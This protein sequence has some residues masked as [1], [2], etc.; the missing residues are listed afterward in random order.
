M[1]GLQSKC[2]LSF[3]FSYF[4]VAFKPIGMRVFF[5]VIVWNSLKGQQLFFLCLQALETG[6]MSVVFCTHKYNNMYVCT[7]KIKSV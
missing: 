5:K 6:S 4:I 1:L 7:K 3:V 2:I